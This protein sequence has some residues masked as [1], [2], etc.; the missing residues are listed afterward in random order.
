MANKTQSR[1]AS[2]A[3]TGNGKKAP[4]T[5]KPQQSGK[6]RKSRKGLTISATDI[7][8]AEKLKECKLVIEAGIDPYA[9]MEKV[10]AQN[11]E[12]DRLTDEVNS[13]GASLNPNQLIVPPRR[14]TTL[15]EKLNE[16]A[17]GSAT[18]EHQLFEIE[19]AL[20]NKLTGD[21]LP[22]RSTT[23]NE[24]RGLQETARFVIMNNNA[25]ISRI[26]NIKELI[27]KL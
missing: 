16:A 15:E 24:C 21:E 2:P 1:K 11:E 13:K 5:G 8:M 12:I 10:I 6:S 27:E 7:E 19:K 3:K 9:L 22:R 25:S 4:L 23:H 26:G 18:I 14:E 20:Y 17:Y